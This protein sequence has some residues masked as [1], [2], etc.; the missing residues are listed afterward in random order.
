M[1]P[2]ARNIGPSVIEWVLGDES[3][4]PLLFC[5]LIHS[6]HMLTTYCV[7]DFQAPRVQSQAG[8]DTCGERTRSLWE[9]LNAVLVC[10]TST[11]VRS[12]G[13]GESDP[14]AAEELLC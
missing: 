2:T 14:A 13:G 3:Q 12:S 4:H 7:P 10:N 8:D 11:A 6:T 9:G 5:L 1:L